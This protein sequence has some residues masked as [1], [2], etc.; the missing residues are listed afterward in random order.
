M[1][2]FASNLNRAALLAGLLGLSAAG[3][4]APA[5][6]DS[7][8]SGSVASGSGAASSG[9]TPPPALE[10]LQAKRQKINALTQQV[11]KIQRNAAQANPELITEQGNY[12]DLVVS[13]MKT[14]SYDPEA[15]VERI[16]ALQTE[17]Q[18]SGDDLAQDQR[19]A[20]AQELQQKKQQFRQ[21][22]QAAMQ[23][24]GVRAARRE[25]GKKMEAAMKKQNPEATQI[26][27]RLEAL[28]SEY[29]TL[30]QKVIQQQ[31]GGGSPEGDQG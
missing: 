7:D 14:D 24:E 9:Q 31:Q 3:F 5:M 17:L 10:E 15:E 18:T 30:L 13:A 2:S 11:R 27:A 28:Q 6:S 22:Q 29:R 16:R 1:I 25:L 26:I 23:N 8:G 20:K 19:Q 4:N 12:R 21:K